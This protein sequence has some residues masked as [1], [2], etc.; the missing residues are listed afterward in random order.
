MGVQVR[1][2]RR[3]DRR[4]AHP[5]ACTG[6]AEVRPPEEER[7]DRAR[8]PGGWPFDAAAAA[9]ADD[10]RTTPALRVVTSE[11]NPL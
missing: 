5:D 4:L 10:L 9:T 2:G 7:P 8:R 1:S 3:V 6:Q 11:A